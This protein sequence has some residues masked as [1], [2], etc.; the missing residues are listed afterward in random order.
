MRA[1]RGIELKSVNLE[2]PVRVA[3]STRINLEEPVRVASPHRINLEEPISSDYSAPTGLICF[4]VSQSVCLSV[5]AK[6]WME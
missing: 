5:W 6:R 3:S 2:E 1:K 4:T